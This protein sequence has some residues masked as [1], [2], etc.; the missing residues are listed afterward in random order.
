MLRFGKIAFAAAVTVLALAGCASWPGMQSQPISRLDIPN[1]PVK[2]AAAVTVPPGYTTYYISG[3]IAAVANPD[4]PAGSTERYGDTEA[5]TASVLAQLKANMAKLGLT[6]AD[7]VA[8]HVFIAG[9]PASGGKMDFIGMNKAWSKE[10]GTAEQPNKPARA[11]F[12]V[13]ALAAPGALVEI[14]FIAAKKVQ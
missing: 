6:F 5:Q 3:A 7:V 14:E 8:A 13:V 9:D 12:Q 10:F 1:A 4:A 11:A 2:I